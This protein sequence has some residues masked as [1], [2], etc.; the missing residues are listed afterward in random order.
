MVTHKE[1]VEAW[2]TLEKYHENTTCE[3]C[4]FYNREFDDCHLGFMLTYYV[5][6]D[7]IA[8]NLAK[9]EAEEK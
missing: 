1:A 9:L 7:E 6:N 4:A 2:K 3:K 5:D 8:Q